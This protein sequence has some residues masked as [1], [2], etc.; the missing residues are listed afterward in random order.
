MPLISLI[1]NHTYA[2]I[3]IYTHDY[4]LCIRDDVL[5]PFCPRR[6]LRDFD[7][8]VDRS[9]DTFPAPRCSV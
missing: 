7:I 8:S 5:V 4:F 3:Y 2:Y 6:A 1:Y 9:E